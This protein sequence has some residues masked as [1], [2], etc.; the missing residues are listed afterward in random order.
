M[1]LFP[2]LV[3]YTVLSMLVLLIGQTGKTEQAGSIT[4]AHDFCRAD[5]KIP[6]KDA[7]IRIHLLSVAVTF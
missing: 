6:L 4:M 1:V 5:H 2:L 3:L 7:L